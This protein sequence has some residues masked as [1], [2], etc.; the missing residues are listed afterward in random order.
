MCQTCQRTTPS[1]VS[2]TCGHKICFSC[3]KLNRNTHKCANCQPLTRLRTPPK[4][5]DHSPK[6]RSTK[7]KE[8]ESKYEYSP[9][10]LELSQPNQH[11]SSVYEESETGTQ[12]IG[13]LPCKKHQEPLSLYSK[14]A[15]E[16]LC[17]V[18][19]CDR[20]KNGT[21]IVPLRMA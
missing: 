11:R 2:A 3:V 8:T 19:I 9:L 1:L 12:G 6:D 7:V 21:D 17:S 20:S 4:R 18:C 14:S 5:T 15:K 10:R 13:L 16:L